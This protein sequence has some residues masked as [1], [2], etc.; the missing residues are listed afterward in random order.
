LFPLVSWIWIGGVVFVL[1]TLICLIPNK[2]G[3][4]RVKP[5]ARVEAQELVKA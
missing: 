1:G 2:Q 3:Q 5:A 4:P